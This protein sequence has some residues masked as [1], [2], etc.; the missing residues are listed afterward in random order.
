VTDWRLLPRF[1]QAMIDPAFYPE[2]PKSVELLQTQMSFVF[3]AGEF[4]YKVK[5]PVNLGYLDYCSLD[6]R[7]HFCERETVLN[8]RLCPDAYLGVVAIVNVGGLPAIGEIGEPIEYAVKMRYLPQEKMLNVLLGKNEVTPAMMDRL[9]SKLADFHERAETNSEI[10]SFGDI[11]TVSANAEE[12]FDQTEKSIGRTISTRRFERIR[13]YTREF[14]STNESLFKRRVT[15]G[16]IRDCHGDLHAAHI[17]LTDAICIYDCIE[18]NDRFRYGDVASEIAFLAM[19]LDHFGRADLSRRFVHGYLHLTN[20]GEILRLLPFYKCYRAYVRGKVEGFKLD[21]PYLSNDDK[22]V[23]SRNASGYFDLASFYARPRPSLLITTG[24]TGTGKTTAAEV[25]SKRTGVFVISSD[26]VRK[27][28][29]GIPLTERRLDSYDAGI[30][31]EDFT[32]RTYDTILKQA[33]DLLSS[34]D[35]VILDA[36]FMRKSDRLKARELADEVRADYFVLVFR[37]TREA[38][39][40]RLAER[41]SSPS[42]SDGRVEILGPQMTQFEQVDEVPG[43]MRVDFDVSRRMEDNVDELLKALG[44][45]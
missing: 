10:A 11:A 31:S 6:S 32:R 22:V 1:A 29:A 12:N 30:Y 4:V 13:K 40:G 34:G 16:R 7:R 20:D 2:R 45:S 17:C 21:D 43:F 35:S 36:T 5:K 14:I 9:S 41:S 19:D 25:I 39:E 42:V 24:V 23:A 28:L 37:G 3:I 8:R 18:F 44:E 27:Q 33:K 38:I 26:V 15:E